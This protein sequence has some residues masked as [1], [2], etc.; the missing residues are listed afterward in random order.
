[1]YHC[2]SVFVMKL[3]DVLNAWSGLTWLAPNP[4]GLSGSRP[5]SR[6]SA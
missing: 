3:M 2:Q 5:W 6:M 1:M 4:C